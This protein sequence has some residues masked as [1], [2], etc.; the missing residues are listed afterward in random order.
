MNYIA[1]KQLSSLLGTITSKHHSH[2]YCLNCLQFFKTEN[3]RESHKISKNK[4]YG[5]DAMPSEKTE[6]LEFDQYQKSDKTFIIYTD[7]ECLIEK[8][9]GCKNNPKNSSATKLDEHIPLGFAMPTILSFKTIENKYDV[10]RGKDCIKKFW[11]SLT[12]HT[13]EII[14]FK[15]EK[16]QAINKY[17]S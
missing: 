12:E 3:K 1:V 7:L 13:M 10:Y 5:N 16:S 9:D 14:S 2:F 4:G 17:K 6:I 8:I 15:E 11:K